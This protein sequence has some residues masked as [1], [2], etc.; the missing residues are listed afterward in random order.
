MILMTFECSPEELLVACK[1]VSIKTPREFLGVKHF[2]WHKLSF[3]L[4]IALKPISIH[5][6]PKIFFRQKT[7]EFGIDCGMLSIILPRYFYIF[8]VV[9]FEVISASNRSASALL[10]FRRARCL[11]F[12]FL[13]LAIS[14]PSNCLFVCTAFHS[15]ERSRR[16]SNYC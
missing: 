6:F 1:W 9:S 13:S 12:R 11:H 10:L 5:I 8:C 3:I 2:S 16:K 4:L 15:R 7:T 14:Q